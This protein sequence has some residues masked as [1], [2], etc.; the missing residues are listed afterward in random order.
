MNTKDFIKL[1]NGERLSNKNEWVF[2]NEA[3]N[4]VD[5][6]YKAFGTWIQFIKAGDFNDGSGSGLNVS[7]FKQYLL[8]IL[9]YINA[10]KYNQFTKG[11]KWD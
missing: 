10:D 3:V 2:L 9:Q 1:A 4:G 5:I 7:E 6:Q 8:E 11:I